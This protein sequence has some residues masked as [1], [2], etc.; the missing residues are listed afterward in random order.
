MTHILTDAEYYEYL[1]N[2]NEL[3]LLREYKK[4]FL[5]HC[6][7]YSE[8]NKSEIPCEGEYGNAGY[9]CSSCPIG[10][11]APF[12]RGVSFPGTCPLG[13]DRVYGK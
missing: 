12:E 5:K 10:E 3:E 11:L 6:K 8:N 1:K 7:E 13:K 9:E 2:K 4:D